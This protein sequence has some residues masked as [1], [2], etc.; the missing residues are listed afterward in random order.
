MD[1]STPSPVE[2]Y[3]SSAGPQVIVS[4][5]VK[6]LN[7]TVALFYFH[8]YAPILGGICKGVSQKSLN[9]I[10]K[11]L[12]FLSLYCCTAKY[13]NNFNHQY[14]IFRFFIVQIISTM[15]H[16]MGIYLI[17]INSKLPYR[18]SRYSIAKEYYI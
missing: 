7:I 15:C 11:Y 18:K 12:I 3:F 8:M 9:V 10:M 5:I 17:N 4:F 6:R 1:G 13:M 2:T 16:G 14:F